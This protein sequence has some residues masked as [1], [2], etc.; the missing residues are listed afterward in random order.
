MAE[1]PGHLAVFRAPT[2]PAPAPAAEPSLEKAPALAPVKES[3]AEKVKEDL[4][5]KAENAVEEAAES[6]VGKS[7]SDADGDIVAKAAEMAAAAHREANEAKLEARRQ[8][9]LVAAAS[10][11]ASNEAKQAAAAKAAEVSLPGSCLCDGIEWGGQRQ[12]QD[13]PEHV[14]VPGRGNSC[15]SLPPPSMALNQ[16][17][18]PFPPQAQVPPQKYAA[19]CPLSRCW[20]II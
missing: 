18:P 4:A 11:K 6:V 7:S 17:P 12:G 2:A 15:C 13:S 9:D 10:G 19:P 8:Q 1:A 5:E 20:V 3:A 14:G 16:A